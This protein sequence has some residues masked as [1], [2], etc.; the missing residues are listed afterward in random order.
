MPDLSYSRTFQVTRPAESITLSDTAY[1]TWKNYFIT[2]TSDPDLPVLYNGKEVDRPNE[3]GL[4][5]VLVDVEVGTNNYT[6]SQN[7]TERT[8]QI[9]RKEPAQLRIPSARLQK[10]SVY[11]ANPEAVLRGQRAEALLHCACGR[12]GDRPCRWPDSR[13]GT[14]LLR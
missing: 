6:F 14:S 9:I 13:T 10:C 5:G 11:P 8:V 7:G 2:G 1:T 4:W 3:N 12:E